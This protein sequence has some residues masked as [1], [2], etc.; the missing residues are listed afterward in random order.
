MYVTLLGPEI[1][2]NIWFGSNAICRISVFTCLEEL[3]EGLKHI[4]N[5]YNLSLLSEW[6]EWEGVEPTYPVLT[7]QNGFEVRRSHRAPTTPIANKT[8]G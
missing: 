6:R 2:T 1:K 3:I 5:L 4:F 7:G 8:P